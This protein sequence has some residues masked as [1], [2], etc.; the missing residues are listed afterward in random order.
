MKIEGLM[1]S[2]YE[3][4]KIEGLR[5]GMDEVSVESRA[6]HVIMSCIK[7]V[8]AGNRATPPPH[9]LSAA[10][11]S[12]I[13]PYNLLHRCSAATTSNSILASPLMSATCTRTA[14]RRQSRDVPCRWPLGRQCFRNSEHGALVSGRNTSLIHAVNVGQMRVCVF[15]RSLED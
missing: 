10:T 11:A 14:V 6:C 9:Y 13:L 3:E 2:M 4:L 12:S 8:L 7:S 5:G 1:W 15:F